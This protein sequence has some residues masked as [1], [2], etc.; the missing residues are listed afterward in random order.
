MRDC[1]LPDHP[2]IERCERTGLAPGQ[3]DERFHC[4]RC[5]EELSVFDEVFA[6]RK[7]GAV[8]GCCYCAKVIESDEAAEW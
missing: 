2:D 8:I 7:S 6:D 3:R 1:E 4:P 5:G